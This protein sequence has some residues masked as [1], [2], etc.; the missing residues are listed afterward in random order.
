MYV[1]VKCI[2]LLKSTNVKMDHLKDQLDY[3]YLLQMAQLFYL[4]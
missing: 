1:S 4:V 2:P 3:F